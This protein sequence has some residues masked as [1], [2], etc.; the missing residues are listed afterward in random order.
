MVGMFA[1]RRPATLAGSF[2]WG[3]QSFGLIN[4]VAEIRDCRLKNF[5][6]FG[7]GLRCGNNLR[8]RSAGPAKPLEVQ[9][10][11]DKLIE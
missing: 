7:D 2:G 5:A 9:I 8:P 3:C 11:R 10:H 1:L 4:D 6:G